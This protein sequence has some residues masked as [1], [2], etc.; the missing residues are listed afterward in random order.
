MTDAKNPSEIAREA[1]KQLTLRHLAPTPANYQA[2]YNEIAKLPNVAPFPEPPLR[3]IAAELVA[4]NPAQGEELVNLD[5]AITRRSWQGVQAALQ[6]FVAAAGVTAAKA[7][8]VIVAPVLPPEFA[9]RLARFVECVLPALGED[10]ERIAQLSAE[11]LQAL[12]QP[13]LDV[14]AIQTMLG[15]L[16]HQA[17]F[18]AEEQVEIKGALLK[19]LHLI[20]EN[21]GE[22]S[23]DDS[24]LKGQVDGLLATVA[25]PL[26][27]RHLDEMERRLR[28][29]MRKQSEAKS[30]SLE[31]QEEMRQMLGAFIERLASMNASSAAFQGHIEESARQIE[32]VRRIED[33]AP[34]LKDVIGATRA[35]AEETAKSR[36]QLQSLQD[37]VLATEAELVQLHLDLDNAS[38]LARH[39]PLTDAL[40]RKGLDEALVREIATMR[41]KDTPLSLCLL[42]ID[43][44]KKLNDRLGHEAGDDA[45]VHLADVARHCMRPCDTLARYGGE[46]FVILMPETTLEQGIEV[47]TRLQRELT[48]AFFLNGKE[49][50]LITF[51]AGVTQLVREESGSD[52]IKRAD[53][54]M[55][56]AKRAGK[57]RVMGG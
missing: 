28:D 20:I 2:C 42:D 18:A 1:L 25:P 17:L 13:A 16:G 44:F 45:L 6:G 10:G 23:L 55:Y 35:M 56:L 50:V 7:P 9:A 27:L 40:N 51:S 30:R 48:K 3:Q 22:L 11:F 54:A 8:E 14:Q 49:R 4:R 21:I 31:A 12:R 46:E 36:E 37:K 43:N 52:A 34:L 5:L 41:R 15:Q 19:L 33:L 57:N 47:I 38:A 53:Q 24:W 39:D 32:N 29:V 26:T